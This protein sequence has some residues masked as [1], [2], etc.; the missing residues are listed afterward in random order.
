MESELELRRAICF[1]PSKCIT[2][3]TTLFIT[4]FQFL[5]LYF[6]SELVILHF[7]NRLRRLIGSLRMGK[8]ILARYNKYATNANYLVS[9]TTMMDII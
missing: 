9:K 3:F 2:K 6:L 4:H 7:N 5:L 1:I 8:K